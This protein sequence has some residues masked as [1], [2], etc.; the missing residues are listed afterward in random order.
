MF[1]IPG[2]LLVVIAFATGFIYGI[3]AC[4]FIYGG[5]YLVMHSKQATLYRK[6]ATFRV[7]PSGVEAGGAIVPRDTA[8]RVL[9]RNHVLQAAEG[10]IVVARQ[11]RSNQCHRRH[12]LGDQQAGADLLPRR[13]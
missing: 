6:P 5:M 10:L 1:A 4:G 3:L 13:R 7:S 12:E 9:I 11:F 2:V 8:H